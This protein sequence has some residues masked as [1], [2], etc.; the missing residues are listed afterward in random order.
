MMEHRKYSTLQNAGNLWLVIPIDEAKSFG[1]CEKVSK[2]S[3]IRD[4]FLL[5]HESELDLF[6]HAKMK[7]YPQWILE[8][9]VSYLPTKYPE[10]RR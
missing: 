2:H 4:G 5:L 8:E 1:L 10:Q 3:T 6:R 9:H 7:K